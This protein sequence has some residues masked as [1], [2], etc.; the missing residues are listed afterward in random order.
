M[1]APARYL[2]DE[3]FAL[4]VGNAPPTRA[5]AVAADMEASIAAARHEAYEAG[6]A[7][8]RRTATE[9]MN[10]RLTNAL[11][12][13]VDEMGTARA[14]AAA[15]H[16]RTEQ[17]AVRLALAAARKLAPALVE[18]QPLA[19]LE[20]ILRDCLGELRSA[21]HLAVRLAESLVEPMRERLDMLQR[22]TGF[23]GQILVLG[24][25][26]IAEGDGRIDWADGGIV[27]DQARMNEALDEAMARYLAATP[28]GENRERQ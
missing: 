28:S 16:L 10:S 8:G 22:Q 7:D 24:D 27:R 21:P 25:P 6:L 15:E 20:A 4:D 18:R 1:A 23:K 9:D 26:E 11:Q 13:F 17:E 19:E 5:A 3:V 2:F 14:A 12:R